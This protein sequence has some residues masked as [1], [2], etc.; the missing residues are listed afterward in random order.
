MTPREKLLAAIHSGSRIPAMKLV[1]DDP[2]VAATISKLVK[3]NTLVD[4]TGINKPE[5]IAIS[6]N[7][8]GMK[9]ISDNLA[10][11]SRNSENLLSLFPELKLSMDIVV[12]SILS[13][14]DMVSNELIYRFGGDTLPPSVTLKIT[15]IIKNALIKEY[16][17]QQ[18]LKE[19]VEQTVFSKGSYLSLVLPE[20]SVDEIINNGLVTSLES[21]SGVIDKEGNIKPLSIL[22]THKAFSDEVNKKSNF[23]RI[24]SEH[25]TTPMYGDNRNILPRLK[26]ESNNPLSDLID[27]TDNYDLC[28]LPVVMQAIHTRK[29]RDVIR[30]RSRKR[31]VSLESTQ[32]YHTQ[33]MQSVINK[34]NDAENLRHFQ[35]LFYKSGHQKLKPYVRIKT[36][37]ETNRKSIGRPLLQHPPSECFIPVTVPG[38]RDNIIGGFLL[39]DEEGNY[40]DGKM[41]L[42]QQMML[43]NGI[44]QA[45]NSVTSYLIAKARNNL[46]ENAVDSLRYEKALDIFGDIVERELAS[47]VEKGIYG[48][49]VEVARNQDIYS[50]ML[51]RTYANQFTRLVY[52]PNELFT[53][54]TIDQYDNGIG[55]SLLD[56]LGTI[57][58]TRAIMLF[59]KVVGLTKSSIDITNVNMQFDPND[60]D[61][62]KTA[63]V[64]MHEVIRMRQQYF[65]LGINT[66]TDLIDWITRAGIQFSFEGHPGIPQVK[67][68]FESKRQD[69]TIPDNDLEEQLRKDCMLHIGVTPEMVDGAGD[70]EFAKTIAQNNLLFTKRIK[71]HQERLSPLLSDEARKIILNDNILFDELVQVLKD[72]SGQ[73][74]NVLDKD[75]KRALQENPELAYEVILEDAIDN[76][77]VE[78][79]RPDNATNEVLLE[80][81]ESYERALDKALDFHINT[82]FLNERTAG[83]LSNDIDLIKESFKAALMRRWMAENN[84]LSE[85]SDIISTDELGKP[86]MD[87]FELTSSHI[88][89]L[90]LNTVKFIEK[91]RPAIAASDKDMDRIEQQD[92]EVDSS[93]S[94]SSSSSD[95]SSGESETSDGGG[96][97]DFGFG[98]EG[99]GGEEGGFGF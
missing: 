94:S 7:A 75:Q 25:F 6:H 18:T 16:G 42:E 78:F 50:V 64:A 86:M 71:Q 88:K 92:G 52:V 40:I 21:L 46:N 60:P 30:S 58:G 77:I 28:K 31:K 33:D 15:D 85:V 87:I 56:D 20:A 53:Y 82:T 9:N 13:P 22:S 93:V 63:E 84:Y 97:G 54:Y 26:T 73:I 3:S 23:P 12:S 67:F 81:L 34:K 1:K 89:G 79:P 14:K 69:H 83:K 62:Q 96:A 37:Y 51:A 48:R 41:K 59:A 57:L 44:T 11:R 70:V 47:K 4:P 45:S 55:K 29:I 90:L 98:S 99:D 35:S 80:N 24:A 32:V 76:L 43:N 49:K 39:I 2:V 19:K 72:N 65:P 91:L 68:D 95:S 27:I 61:P 10:K 8:A 17:F 66:P 36:K 38:E 74:E 5:Q